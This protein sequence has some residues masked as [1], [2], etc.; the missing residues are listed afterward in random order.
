MRSRSAWAHGS[1]EI[2]LAR[3]ADLAMYRAKEG[4]RNRVCLYSASMQ[5]VAPLAD[6]V[7]RLGGIT[8]ATRERPA[9]AAA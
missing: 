7:E 6:T 2:E 4:G 9:Q 1:G 8:P 5:P 3:N